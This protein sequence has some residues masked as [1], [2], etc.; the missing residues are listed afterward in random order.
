MTT[1]AAA[2]AVSKTHAWLG[3]LAAISILWSPTI[4]QACAVCMA[5][6]DDDTRTAYVIA[7]A[8]MT[9]MPFVLLGGFLWWLRRFLGEDEA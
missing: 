5:S 4:A 3:T 6:K 7:T 8:F 1:T 2:T 9:L